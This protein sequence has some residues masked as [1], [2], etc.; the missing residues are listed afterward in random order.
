M[1]DRVA[2][3]RYMGESRMELWST[4]S[5]QCELQRRY[6]SRGLARGRA[7][8]G[9]PPQGMRKVGSCRSLRQGCWSVFNH[10]EAGL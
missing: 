1:L 7:G 2:E 8:I 6:W 9:F 5:I 10:K 3:S 4:L